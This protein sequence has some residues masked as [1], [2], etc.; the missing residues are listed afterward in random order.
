MAHRCLPSRRQHEGNSEIAFARRPG[1]I[2]GKLKM[3]NKNDANARRIPE[4]FL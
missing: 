1:A 4:E 3:A 2:S